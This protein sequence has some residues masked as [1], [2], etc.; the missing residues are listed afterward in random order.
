MKCPNCGA[1][2]GSNKICEFCGSPITA[3]MLREQE[4]LNKAVCPKC[5]ST[6][7]TFNREKKGEIKGKKGSSVVR[8][9]VGLCKDCGYTWNSMDSTRPAKKRKTW[10][11][12]L[13]WI[14]MFPVPLTVLML[15]KKDLKPAVRYGAIAAGWLVFLLIGL[16]GGPADQQPAGVE[17]APASAVTSETDFR[18][19]LISGEAG[20]YGKELVL[21]EGTEFEDRV[22]GYFVP[23]GTYKVTNVG[24]APTQ[25]NVY[26]NEKTM[27]DSNWEE[28][29]DGKSERLEQGAS[30]EMIL[31]EGY[32]FNIDAPS[33][34]VVEK[35]A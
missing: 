30:V 2:I 31:P 18:L 28:W 34:L 23:A 21:N 5:G 24:D 15:R 32:F 1:E 27:N 4:R 14:C 17:S 25:A 10:L 26:K 35:I 3:D 12:V 29:A 33:H 11:W 13:G 20:Q 9:T 6:N 16:L 8:S 19:E 22:I 7:I